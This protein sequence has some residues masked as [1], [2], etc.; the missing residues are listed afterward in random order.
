MNCDVCGTFHDAGSVET[1][2]TTECA[3]PGGQATHLVCQ[4]CAEW[5]GRKGCP[6]CFR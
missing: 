3:C 2:V 4:P 5:I 6:D 1:A